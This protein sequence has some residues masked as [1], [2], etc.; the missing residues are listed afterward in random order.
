MKIQKKMEKQFPY[1]IVRFKPEKAVINVPSGHGFH[2]TQYDLNG[3]EKG[4]K[5]KN[6]IKFPYYIVRFKLKLSDENEE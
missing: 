2:T 1:Y 5:N 6:N 4:G 3:I